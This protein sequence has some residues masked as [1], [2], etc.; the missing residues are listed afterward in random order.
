MK[1]E[2]YRDQPREYTPG[3][4]HA[5]L[6]EEYTPR[7]AEHITAR[8][9]GD[10]EEEFES[11]PSA[12]TGEE[13]KA[14]EEKE[15]KKRKLMRYL[16]AA[17]AMTAVITLSA[18]EMGLISL[19]GIGPAV[20]ESP[21]TD[22]PVTND[23]AHEEFPDW[24]VLTPHAGNVRMADL[25]YPTYAVPVTAGKRY[26]VAFHPEDMTARLA[27]FDYLAEF[28]TQMY[29]VLS[30]EVASML[31]NTPGENPYRL[32]VTDNGLP[33]WRPV[34]MGF[35]AEGGYT[36]PVPAAKGRLE[37]VKHTDTGIYL[38]PLFVRGGAEG[39]TL[40]TLEEAVVLADE[41]VFL[42][43][44][45]LSAFT[46]FNS[47]N[48]GRAAVASAEIHHAD[49]FKKHRAAIAVYIPKFT[50]TEFAVFD[51][52]VAAGEAT[53]TLPTFLS[54]EE[55]DPGGGEEINP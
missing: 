49:S 50:K 14:A 47:T 24:G 45:D 26:R 25:H 4:E 27:Y 5:P 53:L 29:H 23:P 3:E 18:G 51:F 8:E 37:R 44:L 54:L 40:R 32:S 11:V 30:P 39:V 12:P 35:A 15:K 28:Q 43:C 38:I 7:P 34:C 46:D 2:E 42:G 22:A 10:G 13:E 9:Y 31:I 48:Y 6:P 19:P 52:T 16:L 33:S 55:I 17:A 36:V 41:T 21:V 20:T 1:Q